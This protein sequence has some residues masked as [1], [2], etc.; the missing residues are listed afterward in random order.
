MLVTTVLIRKSMESDYRGNNSFQ[1]AKSYEENV[2]SRQYAVAFVE[3]LS[4]SIEAFL[5]QV[6]RN[7]K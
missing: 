4:P 7:R 3:A 5:A 1:S 6:Y 2:A